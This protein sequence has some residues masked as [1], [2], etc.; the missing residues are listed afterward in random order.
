MLDICIIIVPPTNQPMNP[1][2]ESLVRLH[3]FFQNKIQRDKI[4]MVIHYDNKDK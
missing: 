1:G 4:K 2:M 3:F